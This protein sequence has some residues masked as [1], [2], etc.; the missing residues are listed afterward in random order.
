MWNNVRDHNPQVE[1]VYLVQ[2]TNGALCGLEYT[3][4]GGWNTHY[5]IRG[6]LHNASAISDMNVARWFD[7]PDPPEVPDE[8]FEEMRRSEAVNEV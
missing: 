7:A 1:K 6:N 3:K 8:W 2:M 5:D 4:E